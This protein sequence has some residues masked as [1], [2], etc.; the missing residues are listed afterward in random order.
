MD[1][2]KTNKNDTLYEMFVKLCEKFPGGEFVRVTKDNVYRTVNCTVYSVEKG[3]TFVFY[4]VLG[5]I[6]CKFLDEEKVLFD[7][8]RDIFS[9][10]EKDDG[11]IV[12]I[13]EGS[14]RGS[15]NF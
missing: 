4:G 8:R 10:F 11:D 9:V 12:D 13:A 7:I 15:V 3:W 2:A 6:L 14:L 5:A 1:F